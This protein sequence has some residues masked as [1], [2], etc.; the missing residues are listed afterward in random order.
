L[1]E[2]DEFQPHRVGLEV[3]EREVLEAA[4]FGGA[5]AVFDSGAVAVAALEGGDV[6]VGLVGE[7]GLK[8]VAVGVGEGQLGTGV[9]ALAADEHAAGGRPA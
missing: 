6:G 2:Q 3:A 9:R 7:D 5:D 4:V 1:G 8:A